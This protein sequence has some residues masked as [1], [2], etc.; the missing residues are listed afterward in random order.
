MALDPLDRFAASTE[1]IREP[2]QL[3]TYE[4]DGLTGRRVV[5]SLVALPA[6]AAEVQAVVRLCNEEGIPFVARGAGTGL[7]GGALPVAEGIVISLAR[8]TR[9]LDIDL[10]RGQVVV[11]PGVANLDVTRAVAAD[12]FYYAPD[13]SSQQVC[14]IG[15]N[16]AENSGGAHCL[17]YGFTVNH[18]LAADVVLPDGELVELS[19]DD[20]GPDLLGAFVGSEGTLGVAVRITVRVLRLPEAVR[21]LVAG[22]AST[23][24]AGEAV[25][26]TIGA[27]ILPAAI[28]MM[29]TLTIEAAEAAVACNYPAG[30]GRGAPLRPAGPA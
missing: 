12:G 20:E 18:V 4:C 25:S 17:K 10:E 14:T 23:D 15:G 13:P 19:R 8:L 24:A 21:T 26:H 6:N 7:S 28:E 5:P 27:G 30:A 2:E 22:F 29:D 16:V 11:E 9:I 1:T 3:R